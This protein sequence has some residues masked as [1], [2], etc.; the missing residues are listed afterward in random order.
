M[1]SGFN[2]ETLARIRLLIWPLGLLAIVLA[3][4]AGTKWG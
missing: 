4:N 1:F 3:G 2:T